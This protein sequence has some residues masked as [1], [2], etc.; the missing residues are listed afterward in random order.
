MHRLKVDKKETSSMMV[1][2][3]ETKLVDAY[4]NEKA[5]YGGLC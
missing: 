2:K 3:M 4:Y 5:F 1:D